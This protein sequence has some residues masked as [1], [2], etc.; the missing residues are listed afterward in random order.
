MQSRRRFLKSGGWL[1]GASASGFASGVLTA[2]GAA[3]QQHFGQH[4]A[5]ANALQRSDSHEDRTLT[6]IAFGSCLHQDKDQRIWDAVL[7]AHPDL[8][9]FL[10]DSI[11]GDTRDITY[12]RDQYRRLASNPRFQRLR[13]SVPSMAIWDDH[14]FGENDAGIAYP[15]KQQSRQAFL[16]FWNEPQA[17]QR[18][19]HSGVYTSRSFGPPNRRVQVIMPDLRYN[20]TPLTLHDLGRTRYEEWEAAKRA[21]GLSVPGPYARCADRGASMLGEEQ[22]RWFE[23]QLDVQARVRIIASSLQVLA[24]FPGWEAWINYACDHQRLIDTIR[25]KDA[26]GVIFVSGDTHYAELSKL[27]INVPYPLWDLTCS[28]LTEVWDTD[29][30]NANRIGAMMRE[31]NFGL[32][33]IDWRSEDPIVSLQARDRFGVDKVA[34]QLNLSQLAAQAERSTLS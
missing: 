10:G 16:E 7:A 11:Y 20:R 8:F 12:L 31:E 6:R 24:D 1:V 28:G 5:S 21:S 29:V 22:W 4:F 2:E 23:R 30:P 25:R 33:E 14:D 18:W 27:E 32:I 13:E 3:T 9:L 34:H 15:I 26:A 17:S 19:S